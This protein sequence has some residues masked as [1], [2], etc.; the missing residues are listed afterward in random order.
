MKAILA[1]PAHLALPADDVRSH[2]TPD[3]ASRSLSESAIA[4]LKRWYRRDYDFIALC[5]DL[6]LL[7]PLDQRWADRRPDEVPLIQGQD[8]TPKSVAPRV[9]RSTARLNTLAT[10][11][12]TGGNS[13]V[14]VRARGAESGSRTRRS[15]RFPARLW[16][17]RPGSR[18]GGARSGSSPAS[19]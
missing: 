10:P 3:G 14:D 13:R 5:E 4:A 1:L 8:S 17:A 6:N 12:R 18:S 2:R 15:R 16:T 11:S 9:V 7:E 19:R